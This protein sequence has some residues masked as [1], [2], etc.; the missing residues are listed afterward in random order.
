MYRWEELKKKWKFI[1]QRTTLSPKKRKQRDTSEARKILLQYGRSLE[2]CQE[3]DSS[4]KVQVH[5]LDKNPYN[6]H[7]EN[8]AVL[9]RKCHMRRHHLPYGVIDE[10]EGI[11]YE[12]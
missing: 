8:L 12:E 2:R 5:H 9:C 7:I 11:P 1:G 4:T 10:F 3:C 6:N